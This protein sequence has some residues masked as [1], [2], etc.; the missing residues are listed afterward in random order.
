MI[1]SFFF[2][3]DIVVMDYYDIVAIAIELDN[4]TMPVDK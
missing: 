4:F 1:R 2:Q 3:N